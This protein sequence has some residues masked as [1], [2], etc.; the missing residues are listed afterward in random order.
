MSTPTATPVKTPTE[1]YTAD[2]RDITKALPP[3]AD[4][5][6]SY[7]PHALHY[8]DLRLPPGPGPHPVVVFVHGGRWRAEYD[9]QHVSAA[10]AAFTARGVATWNIEFRRVGHIGGGWPGTLL[11]VG[12]ATDFV[13][14][15]ALN[16]NLD[17]NN[18]VISGHS[19]GGHLAQWLGARHRIPAGD[20][21][22]VANPLKPKAVVALA[23]VGDLRRTW[24]RNPEGVE[25]FL[26]GSPEQYPERAA[27]SAACEMLPVGVPF[28]LV[29]GM[30]DALPY[31]MAEEYAERARA[32]GDD[33]Q[34][35]L[36]PGAGHFWLVDPNSPGWPQVED[37]V[38]AAVR[39]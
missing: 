38:I 22:Y 27:T 34:V 37:A 18:V 23:G 9:L 6:I 35:I 25:E 19:S 36:I 26:G 1:A 14:E 7:G 29:N 28:T 21:L 16:Y 12:Q 30:E 8:G 15:L 24:A 33:V 13:R 4:F 3:T 10:C 2:N 5:R 31:S 11:D 32:A 39:R 20:P 17:L